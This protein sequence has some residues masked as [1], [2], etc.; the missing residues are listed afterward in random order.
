MR[1]GALGQRAEGL[2][3]KC[4]VGMGLKLAP[5][6]QETL[7]V[8]HEAQPGG[9]IGQYKL[10]QQLGEG[11]CGVVYMAERERPVRRPVAL[12]ILKLGMEK[13]LVVCG[14]RSPGQCSCHIC[15]SALEWH[16]ISD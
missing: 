12:K 7:R 13:S 11:G 10:L 15:Q 5:P 14:R 1:F 4:L 9:H 3:P 2:C 16:I 8:L 6:D